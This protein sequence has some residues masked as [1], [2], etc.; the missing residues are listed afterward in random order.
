VA[1]RRVFGRRRANY[2]GVEYLIEMRE[3]GIFIRRLR[4]KEEC[5]ISFERLLQYSK[6]Q[7][8]LNLYYDQVDQSNEIKPVSGLW[9]GP[10][11][12]DLPGET[13]GVVHASAEQPPAPIQGWEPGLVPPTGPKPSEAAPANAPAEPTT[14]HQLPGPNPEVDGGHAA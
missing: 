11:V 3:T 8:E 13:N 10:L 2:K 6:P 4:C 1:K 9:Q 14:N 12:P 7:L 5:P